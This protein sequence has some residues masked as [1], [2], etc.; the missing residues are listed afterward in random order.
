[1]GLTLLFSFIKSDVRYHFVLGPGGSMMAGALPVFMWDGARL[2]GEW[3]RRP[4]NDEA[5]MAVTVE[6]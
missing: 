4:R 3:L 5:G 6:R 1:M 2:L